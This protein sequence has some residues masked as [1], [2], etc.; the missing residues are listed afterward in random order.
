MARDFSHRLKS[1]TPSGIDYFAKH[2]VSVSRKKLLENSSWLGIP[3]IGRCKRCGK[4]TPGVL[5]SGSH[6]QCDHPCPRCGKEPFFLDNIGPY[7]GDISRKNLKDAYAFLET[8]SDPEEI[9]VIARV[10][11]FGNPPR[12]RYDLLHAIRARYWKIAFFE[13]PGL[14]GE[15]LTL[16]ECIDRWIHDLTDPATRRMYEGLLLA[17]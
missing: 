13:D 12:G 1:G 6:R 5:M 14:R 4:M 10:E 17:Y 11:I 7:T 15:I 3:R 16:N 8:I 9:E 2:G